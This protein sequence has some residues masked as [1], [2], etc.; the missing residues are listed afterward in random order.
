MGCYGVVQN[1][2]RY[3]MT[4]LDSDCTVQVQVSVLTGF[5][6][7]EGRNFSKYLVFCYLLT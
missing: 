1:Y 6:T 5:A 3:L 7:P 2:R 4:L